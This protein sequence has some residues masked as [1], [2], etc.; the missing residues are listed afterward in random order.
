MMKS[1][2]SQYVL[3][4]RTFNFG[5]N[6]SRRTLCHNPDCITSQNWE[7]TL[8]N[9]KAFFLSSILPE[10][11]KLPEQIISLFAITHFIL[12]PVL[13]LVQ[14]NKSDCTST[15]TTISHHVCLSER[16]GYI[17]CKRNV[18]SSSH[19]LT[20]VR[21]TS[22]LN[23]YLLIA[24]CP[25]TLCL[26]NRKDKKQCAA[27]HVAVTDVKLKGVFNYCFVTHWR[28][29]VDPRYAKQSKQKLL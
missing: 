14:T 9:W 28:S 27:L 21:N 17:W 7:H 15:W 22:T 26:P 2:T 3:N 24:G 8:W 11:H 12:I 16:F 13:I 29:T 23:G 25:P 18:L 4:I 5:F 6:C 20:W 19:W 1:L 10:S